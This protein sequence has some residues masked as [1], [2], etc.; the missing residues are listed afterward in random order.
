MNNY[1]QDGETLTLTAPY[2]CDSGEGA[3]VG[4]I[5]G[6]AAADVAAA[7]EGEFMTEGV[8]ELAKLNTSVWVAGQKVYWD[9]T[10]QRC[11]GAEVGPCIGT[12]VEAAA[13]PTTTGIVRLG[14]APQHFA[15]KNGP[16]ATSLATVGPATLTA[17][18]LL[19]G[20]IVR[21]C[22]GASRTDT[23]PTAALLVAAV[24]GAQ[25]GDIVECL[26]I[27]GSDPVTEIIT[28]DAGVGGAFDANQTAVSR[29]IL[30]TC[31]KL[32]RIRLT[33]VTAAAE[34]YVVYA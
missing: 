18:Q 5:F 31:S 10:N 16:A 20:I 7:A 30:G 29:T 13:N 14:D 12:A 11:D 22:A 3:L 32:V 34:A 17:A 24:P 27:N 8:F 28:L 6:V 26:I 21:D 25:I 19:S 1:V 2:A 9:D 33:N 15:V 23:L 4:K